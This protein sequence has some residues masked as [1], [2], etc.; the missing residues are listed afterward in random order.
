MTSVY[1]KDS[2][3]LFAV[4]FLIVKI[5][6]GFYLY[7]CAECKYSLRIGRRHYLCNLSG[8]LELRVR[9]CTDP[10]W[11]LLPSALQK[12]S[13]CWLFPQYPRGMCT[14]VCC[15]HL[16]KRPELG[17][18]RVE[19]LPQGRL[20]GR[21]VEP[22]RLKSKIPTWLDSERDPC[23]KSLRTKGMP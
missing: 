8:I 5:L 14:T 13:L 1:N 10:V 16:C 7:K 22:Q 6:A 17:D 19:G 9:S 20:Q 12:A 4:N 3:K 23:E 11:K 2:V 21:W 18:E 15:C